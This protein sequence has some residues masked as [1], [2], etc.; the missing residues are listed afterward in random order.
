VGSSQVPISR[1]THTTSPLVAVGAI[2]ALGPGQLAAAYIWRH[3]P[4]DRLIVSRLWTYEHIDGAQD[5]NTIIRSADFEPAC[6]ALRRLYGRRHRASTSGESPAGAVSEVVAL[7]FEG[8]ARRPRSCV[9]RSAVVV[10]SQ[11][12]PH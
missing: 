2:V 6:R 12:G 1:E 4:W 9:G 11:H 10:H 5:L 8:A 3:R 7:R